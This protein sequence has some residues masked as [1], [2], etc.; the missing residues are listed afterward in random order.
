ML[1]QERLIDCMTRLRDERG[2]AAADLAL[3]LQSVAVVVLSLFL[4][5]CSPSADA[6]ETP[7]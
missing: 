1:E 3:G 4:L 2:R 7:V 6:W 5:V